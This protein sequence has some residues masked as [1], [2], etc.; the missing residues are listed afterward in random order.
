M[1]LL[2]TVLSGH[3]PRKM[4]AERMQKATVLRSCSRARSNQHR[5]LVRVIENGQII[6]VI[7][8]KTEARSHGVNDMLAR[9]LARDRNLGIARVAA[10]VRAA[11]EGRE[12]AACL[13]KLF[14]TPV[15]DLTVDATSAKAAL[16]GRV[17]DGRRP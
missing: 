4:P 15:V 13:I 8:A 5:V 3:M 1:P 9:E 16:V 17:D 11:V 14:A 7:G 2:I 6:V 12:L 10:L